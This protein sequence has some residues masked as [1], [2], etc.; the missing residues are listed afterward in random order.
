M[1]L[2]GGSSIFGTGGILSSISGI[3]DAVGGGALNTPAGFLATAAAAVNTYQNVKSLT[4]AGAVSQLTNA[5]A[6][7]LNRVITQGISGQQQFQFPTSV[8]NTI[9]KAVRGIIPGGG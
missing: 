9:T 5:A 6:G 4:K 1:A 3:I 2:G 8:D 7:G